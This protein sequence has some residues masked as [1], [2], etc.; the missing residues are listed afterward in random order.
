MIFALN[1]MLAWLMKTRFMIE[2][3]E[4]WSYDYIKMDCEEGKCYGVLAVSASF[5]GGD[6]VSFIV[7]RFTVFASPLHY[8]MLSSAPHLLA[9][10]TPATRGQPFKMGKGRDLL[11]PLFVVNTVL[12]GGARR[13]YSGLSLSSCLSSFRMASLYSGEAMS[14][15]LAPPFLSFSAW[16]SWWTSPTPGRRLV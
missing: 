2:L 9:Y 5:H 12:A 1:S 3:I 7:N 15:S 14:L 10:V 4:K 11:V 13:F 8:S 16:F 6:C